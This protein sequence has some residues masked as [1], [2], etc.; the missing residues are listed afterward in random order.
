MYGDNILPTLAHAELVPKPTLR[1]T[2]GNNSLDSMYRTSKA[3]PTNI[4]P[5]TDSV[6]R[7]QCRAKYKNK[8]IPSVVFGHAYVTRAIYLRNTA[9]ALDME[10]IVIC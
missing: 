6:T 4:F 2:V 1:T 10:N 7:S 3:P 8:M 9:I 5:S